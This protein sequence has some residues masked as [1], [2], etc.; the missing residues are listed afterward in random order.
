MCP[1]TLSDR[2]DQTETARAL[3]VFSTGPQRTNMNLQTGLRSPY[4][5]FQSKNCPLFLFTPLC[6]KMLY[7]LNT[8]TFLGH[9]QFLGSL[10]VHVVFLFRLCSFLRLT[11][12]IFRLSLLL[13]LSPFLGSSL[14]LGSS[15]FLG[16]II[17][18][19]E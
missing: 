11:Q 8:C 18:L 3:W 4:L 16:D 15:S 17:A 14:F 6:L 2:Y 9:H 12:F 13:W 5:G 19:C 7:F 1:R 10:K